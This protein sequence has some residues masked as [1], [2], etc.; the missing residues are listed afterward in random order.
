M[1]LTFHY[2]AHISENALID[3]MTSKPERHKELVAKIIVAMNRCRGIGTL[4]GLFRHM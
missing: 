4:P 2:T 1:G 3:K